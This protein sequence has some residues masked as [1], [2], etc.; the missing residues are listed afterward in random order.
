L[1]TALLLQI[2]D[3]VSDE[4]ARQRACVDVRWKVAL[5]LEMESRPFAKSTLQLFQA[6]LILHERVRLPFER[7]SALAPAA[8]LSEAG[9][10]VKAG[11]AHHRSAG[12]GSG[13]GHLLS[14]AVSRVRRS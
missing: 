12:P 6:Q 9:A 1:A 10:E 14:A 11:P 3:R 7:S 8:R 4:E 2:H 13:E 5:G